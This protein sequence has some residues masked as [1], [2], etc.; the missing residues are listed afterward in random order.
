MKTEENKTKYC[1][2]EN[3]IFIENHCKKFILKHQLR[4]QFVKAPLLVL[5]YDMIQVLW[6]FSCTRWVGGC[7]GCCCWFT[8]QRPERMDSCAAWASAWWFSAHLATVV[9]LWKLLCHLQPCLSGQWNLQS[10]SA[11]SCEWVG[12]NIYS[13]IYSQWQ[14]SFAVMTTIIF[15]NM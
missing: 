5:T 11:Q 13:N 4:S 7:S 10:I 2:I 9:G 6:G 8:T 12:S 14:M 3:K 1:N 15:L